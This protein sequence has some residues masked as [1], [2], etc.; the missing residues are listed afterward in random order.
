MDSTRHN[1]CHAQSSPCFSGSQAPSRLNYLY[2]WVKLIYLSIQVP[3]LCACAHNLVVYTWLCVHVYIG[4]HLINACIIIVTKLVMAR[5][6][7]WLSA[8]KHLVT[9]KS[10]LLITGPVL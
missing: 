6:I 3:W 8:P 9:T 1:A 7:E 5:W 4:L 10:R 2:V